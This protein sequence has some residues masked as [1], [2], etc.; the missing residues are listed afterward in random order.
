MRDL[1]TITGPAQLWAFDVDEL[2]ATAQEP[3]A[4]ELVRS[5]GSVIVS[6]MVQP[7]HIHVPGLATDESSWLWDA[8]D[9][10]LIVPEGETVMLR[11]NRTAR[12]IAM[13]DEVTVWG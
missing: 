11:A 13:V 7:G 8:P 1:M 12:P 2:D 6:L 5:T 3:L 9:G 4:V 10:P